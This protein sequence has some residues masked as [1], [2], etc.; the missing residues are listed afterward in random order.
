M[1]LKH[2]FTVFTA[3]YNR[4]ETLGR[5]YESLCRQTFRDFEWLVIDDGSTGEIRAQ[6]EKW[7]RDA[8]FPIRYFW[9]EN[10]GKAAAHNRAVQEADGRFFL[11]LDDDDACVPNALERFYYH[12]N[13]IP[14]EE[15][16]QFAGV[17]GLCVDQHGVLVG[18]PFPQDPLDSST[19]D[20]IYRWH[21]SGEKWG[22]TRTDILRRF[23]FPLVKVETGPPSYV[24]EG[25]VWTRIARHYRSRYV[26][27]VLRIFY[28][29]HA[30][31]TSASQTSLAQMQRNAPGRSLQHEIILNEQIDYLPDAP[32]AFLRSAVHYVRFSLHSGTPLAQQFH[33]LKNRKA[34]ALYVLALPAGYAAYWRDRRRL[35]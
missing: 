3:A 1:T 23:P 6:I 17:V 35:S 9:Q 12:W 11:P 15:Q 8:Y 31:V 10:S 18:D 27:D 29:G 24:P 25:I 34:R 21:V 2:T 28:V 33:S 26:N 32:T 30:S 22:F 19:L 16:S 14:Y 13:T 7:Q 4:V 20:L 5:G